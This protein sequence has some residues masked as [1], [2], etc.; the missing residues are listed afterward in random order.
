MTP[1][2]Y[3]CRAK[4]TCINPTLLAGETVP[5]VDAELLAVLLVVAHPRVHLRRVVSVALEGA[6]DGPDGGAEPLRHHPVHVV[7]PEPERRLERD[8]GV[9]RHHVRVPQP[10]EADLPPG[11]TVVVVPRDLQRAAPVVL[12]P[13]G[14]RPLCVAR[15]AV[16]AVL[17]DL[18]YVAEICRH[19]AIS[20]TCITPHKGNYT[21]QLVEDP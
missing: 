18:A 2:I 11:R 15:V 3:T 8:H 9:L 19:Q 5:R 14:A 10:V 16:G 17:V 7:H 13:R 12:L 6:V 4:N 1:S 20:H 21:L